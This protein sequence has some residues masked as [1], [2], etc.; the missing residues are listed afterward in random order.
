MQLPENAGKEYVCF[1]Y[2]GQESGQVTKNTGGNR[3]EGDIMRREGHR[4]KNVE[5]GSIAWQQSVQQLVQR[6]GL[7]LL[8]VP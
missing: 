4:I 6:M 7:L 2:T 1:T 3:I 8:S 5:E